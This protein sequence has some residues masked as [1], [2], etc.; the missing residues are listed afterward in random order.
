MKAEQFREITDC[1]LLNE[2]GDPHFLIHKFKWHTAEYNIS[3]FQV[4][5]K[6]RERTALGDVY[7]LIPTFEVF[8]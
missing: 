7:G 6:Y 5:D 4:R 8:I 1:F 2:L 3:R